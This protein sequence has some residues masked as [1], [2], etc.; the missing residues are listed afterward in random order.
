[1]CE[2][3]WAICFHTNSNSPRA[4]KWYYVARVIEADGKLWELHWHPALHLRSNNRKDIRERALD[5][6]LPLLLG[7]YKQTTEPRGGRVVE[8]VGG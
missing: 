4:L 3:Y 6:G 7:V 1:M 5:A 8:R 2:P